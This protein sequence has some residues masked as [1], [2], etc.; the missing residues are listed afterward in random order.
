M[1]QIVKLL[2]L[3]PDIQGYSHFHAAYLMR[4]SASSENA[5]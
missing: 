4:P 1:A 5:G 2:Y 3:A